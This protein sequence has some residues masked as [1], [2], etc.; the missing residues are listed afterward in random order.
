ML[1]LSTQ[2]VFA[3]KRL[4]NEQ[5]LDVYTPTYGCFD[6]RYWA[7]KLVDYAEATYQRNVY[8]LAWMLKHQLVEDGIDPTVLTDAIRAGLIFSTRIQHRD[9]SFDQ[10][11]P[12]EHSFGAA[13]FMLHPLIYAYTAVQRACSPDEQSGIEKTLRKSA[14]F[15]YKHQE[16]HGHIAN[17]LAGAVLALLT[18][19]EFFADDRYQHRALSILDTILDHQ[20]SEGWFVEYEGADP[21]YQTLCLYYLAQVYNL[22]PDIPGLQDSLQRGLDFLKWFVHPD[23][24]FA[25]EYGSRRTA[26]YYPGGVAL[27]QSDF[28]AARS[29]SQFMIKSLENHRLPTVQNIDIGNL[30]PLL[31]N[32][33]LALSTA[34]SKI[35]E[36]VTP[37]PCEQDCGDMDFPQAGLYIRSTPEYYAIVGTSNGGVVKIFDRTDKK[38]VWNDAGYS[39]RLGQNKAVTTQITNLNRPVLREGRT[40]HIEAPFYFM[41]HTT[42]TPMQFLVLRILNLSLMR[43]VAIG[44]IVKSFMVRLLITGK[45]E[46]PL[47]LNRHLRFEARKII[48]EDK[49]TLEP[50]KKIDYLAFGKPFVA[51]HMAS[52]RYTDSSVLNPISGQV[53]TVDVDALNANKTVTTT[54]TVEL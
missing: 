2:F 21:G 33:A 27:L 19:A 8:P 18:S 10:A 17:H 9:G 44:N 25:G 49:V 23:G 47:T 46:A 32:Y 30:A 42:P 40:I 39:G 14:D 4:L 26:L 50:D 43:Y 1:P 48:I 36:T 20:S 53:Q 13:A 7:W 3:C 35:K 37:L 31:S 22:R 16:T 5:N 52:S 6:R 11:F 34:R 28:E 15:L 51:I 29:I 12:H 38:I 54:T 45:N 24:T 41:L